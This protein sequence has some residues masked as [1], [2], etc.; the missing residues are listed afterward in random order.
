[1]QHSPFTNLD[2]TG[3]SLDGVGYLDQQE[4]ARFLWAWGAAGPLASWLYTA[5]NFNAGTELIERVD[6]SSAPTINLPATYLAADEINRHLLAINRFSE[7]EQVANDKIGAHHAIE[8]GRCTSIADRRWPREERPHR[9]SVMTCGG[10]DQLSMTFRPPRWVGDKIKVDCICGYV[11]N[12]AEFALVTQIVAAD[13]E[14][15]KAD[16]EV[17]A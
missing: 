6:S 4:W 15:A 9:I 13:F 10:C 12:E 14:A 7:P 11:L 1:M 8:L 17:A 16:V 2:H 3:H 5:G